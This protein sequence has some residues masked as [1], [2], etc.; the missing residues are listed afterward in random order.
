MFVVARRIGHNVKIVRDEK[1]PSF[2]PAGIDR[3][4]FLKAY[5][6]AKARFRDGDVVELTIRLR[7]EQ[8]MQFA[9]AAAEIRQILG[10]DHS[11]DNLMRMYKR[12]LSR[13]HEEYSVFLACRMFH[14][15]GK[16]LDEVVAKIAKLQDGQPRPRQ[17]DAGFVNRLLDRCSK[18]S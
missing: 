18:L 9:E 11:V 16:T 10:R 8:N 2:F 17:V 7:I 3:E 14:R 1:A 5:E 6:A 4:L 12:F 15:D 13:V